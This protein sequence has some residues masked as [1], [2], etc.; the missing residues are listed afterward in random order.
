MQYIGTPWSSI[1]P[2]M[3]TRM[4]TVSPSMT[5]VSS[6]DLFTRTCARRRP[7]PFARRRPR[8]GGPSWPGRGRVVPSGEKATEATSRSCP[9]N[10]DGI[11]FQRGFPDP[12]RG[13]DAARCQ[14]LAVGRECQDVTAPACPKEF[15]A[16]PHARGRVPDR[17]Q[18]ILSPA[19]SRLPSGGDPPSAVTRWVCP[20]NAVR[21][22][23]VDVPQGDGPVAQPDGQGLPIGGVG[24]AV[25]E[26]RRIST[27]HARSRRPRRRCS[28][29]AR[30][31]PRRSRRAKKA[32]VEIMVHEASRSATI[33]PERVPDPH[34]LPE[35][36]P[37]PG[38]RRARRP[39]HGSPAS[40]RS[41][42]PA[43]WASRRSN[44]R[45]S[46]RWGSRGGARR[47]VATAP[48]LPRRGSCR[49]ARTPQG[50]DPVFLCP[51]SAARSRPVATSR[52]RMMSSRPT[53]ATILRSGAKA[54][55]EME[56]SFVEVN[57]LPVAAS[58]TRTDP[59]L[60][61][62][63]RPAAIPGECQGPDRPGGIL[64]S[65]APARYGRPTT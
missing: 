65:P 55:R 47:N 12:D 4:V 10:I 54:I 24:E 49:R 18:A 53:T 29:T 1:S 59:S 50:P 2:G 56:T 8:A 15:S 40:I 25:G 43:P 19:A 58:Q 36:P 28:S 48:L 34:L 17:D 42:R 9:R 33:A 52:S 64:T 7:S 23:P 63:A 3:A 44:P 35:P 41:G 26:S 46:P 16:P 39:R 37:P 61:A 6:F 14:R 5:W 27:A 21:T 31:P 32:I 11:E 51:F 30:L 20:C 57:N 60:P 38:D 22:R 13:V 62:E 45:A